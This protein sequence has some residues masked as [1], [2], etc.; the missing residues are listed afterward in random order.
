MPSEMLWGTQ[1]CVDSQISHKTYG[2]P[3]ALWG[4]FEKPRGTS[5]SLDSEWH[6]TQ[7]SLKHFSLE[8]KPPTPAD[9]HAECLP[10]TVK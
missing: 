8:S 3:T 10:F 6:A 4:L 9:Y 5:D 2:R 7:L 1:E